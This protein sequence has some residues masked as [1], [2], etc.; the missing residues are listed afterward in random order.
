MDATDQQV[1]DSLDQLIN[2]KRAFSQAYK[3]GLEYTEK[4]PHPNEISAHVWFKLAL[5]ASLTSHDRTKFDLAAMAAPDYSIE[6]KGDLLRDQALEAIRMDR[7]ELARK[8]VPQIE[9]L[10]RDDQNRM[11][12]WWMLKG[13][14]AFAEDEVA[15][16]YEAYRYADTL[17]KEI[18][19]EADSQ[20]VTNNLFH[21]LRASTWQR[22]SDRH[23]IYVEFMDREQSTGRRLRAWSIRCFGRAGLMVDLVLE[24]LVS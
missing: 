17:W 23:V 11:A 7:I 2:K 13:R 16:A 8:M 3:A 19:D 12:A 4:H 24:K 22:Y 1:I 5:L 20:W 9:S 6:M 21:L 18:G 14:I 10:H 15:R